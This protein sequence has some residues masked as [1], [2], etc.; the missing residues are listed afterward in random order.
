MKKRLAEVCREF[1]RVHG[2][3]QVQ[4]AASVGLSPRTWEGIEGGKGFGHAE[5]LIL[6]MYA[7]SGRNP[8]DESR[9]TQNRT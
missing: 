4:A 3:T 7:F 1:R 6:A 8:Y 5:M 9:M 2:L